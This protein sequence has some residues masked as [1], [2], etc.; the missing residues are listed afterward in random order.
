MIRRLPYKV[1]D[2]IPGKGRGVIALRR[3][4]PDDLVMEITGQV[5]RDAKYESLY[6]MDLNGRHVIE[7]HMPGGLVNHS[8]DPNCVLEQ[9]TDTSM[10]LYAIVNIEPGREITYDY[11]WTAG[12]SFQRCRCGSAKCRGYIVEAGKEHK[13]HLRMIQRALAK[14]KTNGHAN[15]KPLKSKLQK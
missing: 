8:C 1:I 6:C 14:T 13:R 3:F 9:Y 2:N 10:A 4:H 12:V 5:I 15:G 7:P 11:G